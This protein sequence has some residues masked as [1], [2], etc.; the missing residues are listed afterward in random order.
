[1]S[2]QETVGLT[3]KTARTVE[4]CGAKRRTQGIEEIEN[5]PSAPPIVQVQAVI[6]PLGPEAIERLAQ[7]LPSAR[8]SFS[9]FR[10]ALAKKMRLYDMSLTEI[11]QLMSQILTESEF[12]SFESAVDTP[13]FHHA[14]KDDL[15]EGVLRA[16]KN[17]IGPK[18]DWS[19]V[20]SCV[21]IKEE[22]VSEYPERFYQS[23]VA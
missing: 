10:R 17:I 1:M 20:T 23:A 22:T 15:K 16:L 3:E 11:T 4:V 13:E 7:N 18:V 2:I 9:E 5:V 12:S 19:R 8:G 14:S 6:K 21:Q